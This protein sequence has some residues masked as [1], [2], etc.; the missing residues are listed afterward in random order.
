M[1]WNIVK[2]GS[3]YKVR[4]KDTGKTYSKKPMP[5]ARA[6]KQLAAMYANYHE[7]YFDNELN[8]VLEQIQTEAT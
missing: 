8:A 1:P 3:G 7:S 2:S 5:K 4:N 6:K